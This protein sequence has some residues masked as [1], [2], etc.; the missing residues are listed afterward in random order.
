LVSKL[1]A[2]IPGKHVFQQRRDYAPA[3]LC[4]TAHALMDD[5]T[6]NRH[7]AIASELAIHAAVEPQIAHTSGPK[8]IVI[9][10][11]R[12]PVPFFGKSQLVNFKQAHNGEKG[13]C[14]VHK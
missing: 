2:K 5:M 1:N 11:S 13:V 7:W 6:I 3:T 4:F 12:G 9:F 14:S 8:K 10:W